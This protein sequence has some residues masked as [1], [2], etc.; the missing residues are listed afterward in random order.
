MPDQRGLDELEFQELGHEYLDRFGCITS[1]DGDEGV[2][3]GRLWITRFKETL[4]VFVRKSDGYVSN[5]AIYYTEEGFRTDDYQ[6]YLDA[7]RQALVLERLAD[8]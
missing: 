6:C 5:N 1:A 8:V 3:L 2:Y 4:M 7:L